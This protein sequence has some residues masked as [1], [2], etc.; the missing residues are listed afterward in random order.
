MVTLGFAA[1]KAHLTAELNLMLPSITMEQVA[2]G[3]T[4]QLHFDQHQRGYDLDV[5]DCDQLS[6]EDVLN[7]SSEGSEGVSEGASPASSKE[8]EEPY[9]GLYLLEPGD[10]AEEG[11][12]ECDGGTEIGISRETA[13]CVETGGY[14]GDHTPRT[15]RKRLAN[16][17]AATPVHGEEEVATAHVSTHLHVSPQCLPVCL[18]PRSPSWPLPSPP[19]DAATTSRR[20]R[21]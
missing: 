8:W 20:G 21:K 18:L 2:A 14:V 5:G 9:P 15:A 11:S 6:R 16:S 1:I 10:G 17:P 19:T 12:G 7:A 3:I 4:S 13:G